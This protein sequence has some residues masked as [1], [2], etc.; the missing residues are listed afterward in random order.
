MEE[1]QLLAAMVNLAEQLLA[2]ATRLVA[3]IS[4]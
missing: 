4:K 3:E 1:Q 2:V